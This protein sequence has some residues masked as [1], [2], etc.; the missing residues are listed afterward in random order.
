MDLDHVSA[1]KCTY[2]L[3]AFPP[4]PIQ[5][6]LFPKQ[7]LRPAYRVSHDHIERIL[8]RMSA[9]GLC[10]SEMVLDYLQRQL[11]HNCRPNTIRSSGSTILLFLAFFKGT[12]GQH[13][14]LIEPTRAG[15]T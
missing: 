2:G 4:N 8:R 10:G 6:S 12:G 3:K 15:A 5:L 7:S 1:G 13:L 11:R 14:P 9:G